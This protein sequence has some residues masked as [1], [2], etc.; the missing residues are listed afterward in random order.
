MEA[1]VRISKNECTLFDIMGDKLNIK[2]FL[3]RLVNFNEGQAFYAF[4]T[5]NLNKN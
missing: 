1:V 4:F 5:V 3:P 2:P